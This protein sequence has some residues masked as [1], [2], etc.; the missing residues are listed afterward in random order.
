MKYVVISIP[1]I[2]DVGN[3]DFSV[4]KMHNKSKIYIFFDLFWILVYRKFLI[5]IVLPCYFFLALFTAQ[6]LFAVMSFRRF[7]ELQ[8]ER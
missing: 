8:K 6:H 5:K 1:W 7:N 4:G 2:A 3:N